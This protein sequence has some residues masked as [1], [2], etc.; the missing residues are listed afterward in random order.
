MARR[1]KTVRV[2]PSNSPKIPIAPFDMNSIQYPRGADRNALASVATLSF[3]LRGEL[4][5]LC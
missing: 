2:I 1:R 3:V 5:G 4:V